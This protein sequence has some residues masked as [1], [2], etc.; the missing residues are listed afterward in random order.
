MFPAAPRLLREGHRPLYLAAAVFTVI[1]IA[2]WGHWI[3]AGIGSP[4]LP[5]RAI[6]M[7]WHA[8]ELIFGYGGAVMA[9]IFLANAPKG[10][11]WIF[12]PALTLLWIAG[13]IAMAMSATL[14][15]PLVALIDLGF[16]LVVMARVAMPLFASKLT[17]ENYDTKLKT[18]GYVSIFLLH[19][20]SNFVMHLDWMGVW[21][22]IAS[23]GAMAGLMACATMN[24]AFGG[25][26][27]A[28]LTRNA[29]VHAGETALPRPMESLDRWGPIFTALCV[30]AA[31]LP[32][33]AF[34][35]VLVL[36]GATNLF[37]IMFWRSGWAFKNSALLTG[38]HLGFMCLGLG[39][40]A[41]GLSAVT[42][43]QIFPGATHL[44]AIGAVAGLSMAVMMK[45]SLGRAGRPG[46]ATGA[47]KL[48][49][50][51]LILALVLRVSG[52]KE[53]VL[54][55]SAIFFAIAYAALAVGLAPALLGPKKQP[56]EPGGR[57]LGH[58][59]GHG[60]GEGDCG[61]GGHGEGQGGMQSC[62][63]HQIRGLQGSCDHD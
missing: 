57:P 42:A 45:T 31:F 49:G 46:H 7:D 51:A 5:T 10:L 37:R 2:L 4:L 8:H 18:L 60:K 36:A 29:M 12:F 17:Q 56:G 38:F 54:M 14:P 16:D 30:P 39:L 9:G 40:Y 25:Q 11:G 15:A 44:L 26:L 13:R 59:H 34:G 6:G 21:P 48:A 28:A 22:G 41:M 1:A 35:A 20:L 23:T 19:F 50:A 61:C 3:G 53:V 62:G 43:M 24:A 27:T 47:L 33:R 32:V 63:L 52:E 55:A 58:G